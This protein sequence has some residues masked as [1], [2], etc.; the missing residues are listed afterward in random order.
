MFGLRVR[1]NNDVLQVSSERPCLSVHDEGVL[2]I[3]TAYYTVINFN[4]V[5][6]TTQPPIIFVRAERG[7]ASEQ[8]TFKCGV[9]GSPGNWTGF[10]LVNG[11]TTQINYLH[12]FAAVWAPLTASG[13]YGM[14]VRDVNGNICF[15]SSS[16]L[17][18][19]SRFITSWTRIS[20]DSSVSTYSSGQTLAADEYVSISQ[21][22]TSSLATYNGAKHIGLTFDANNV[23]KLTANG[24]T[25]ANIGYWP[26]LLAKKS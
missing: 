20:G 16:Q 17:V 8:T 12:W 22:H 26:V 4:Q 13:N 7:S 5:C 23:I 9:V 11:N 21:F 19:F 14:R 6:T 2:A 15:H 1:N 18:K 3:G 24:L 10:R 25:L